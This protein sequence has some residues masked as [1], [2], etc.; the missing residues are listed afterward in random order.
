MH[1]LVNDAKHTGS[2]SPDGSAITSGFKFEGDGSGGMET[3][4]QPKIA[5]AAVPVNVWLARARRELEHQWDCA[6][7][8]IKP[9]VKNRRVND[10]QV[11][12]P[13][14]LV[15]SLGQEL[16]CRVKPAVS[17][18]MVDDPSC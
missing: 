17:V 2:A 1:S 6:F 11:V 7:L 13:K 18:F 9:R 8:G 5:A 16:K 12:I 15:K 3:V 10:T 4:R 14:W